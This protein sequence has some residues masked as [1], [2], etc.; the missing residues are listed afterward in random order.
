MRTTNLWRVTYLVFD[1]ADRKLDMGFEKQ[2]RLLVS[3]IRPDWQVLMWSATW[4]KEVQKLAHDFLKDGFIQL[5]VGSE[6]GKAGKNI[7]QVIAYFFP[8]K[9][10]N[11]LDALQQTFSKAS[12]VQRKTTE[13]KK[14]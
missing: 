14:T 3:Q 11:S 10:Q 9:F 8:R 1:E 13:E 5:N 4:P 2:I 7:K 6:S 12:S